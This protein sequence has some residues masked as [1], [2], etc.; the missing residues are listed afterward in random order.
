MSSVCPGGVGAH[1]GGG[2]VGSV[3]EVEQ[4]GAFGVVELECAGDGVQDRAETP[5]RAP[6]SSLA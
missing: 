2:A 5:A 1:P 3:G 6:R 4:V